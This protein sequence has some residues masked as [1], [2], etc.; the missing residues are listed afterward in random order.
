[1][2]PFNWLASIATLGCFTTAVTLREERV[3]S[4]LLAA[5]GILFLF[6]VL[7]V[8]VYFALYDPA[9][10]QT[11]AHNQE[12]RRLDLIAEKGKRITVLP[13]ALR[14]PPELYPEQ[15]RALPEALLS[16]GPSGG[17]GNADA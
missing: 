16:D 7:A 13:T 6:A 1:M 11:E 12:L 17:D 5:A 10:L 8:G 15:A 3:L 4:A 2:T 14:E 9:R